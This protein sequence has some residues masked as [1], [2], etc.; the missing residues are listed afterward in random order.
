[1]MHFDKKSYLYRIIKVS[2]IVVT[3][4]LSVALIYAAYSDIAPSKEGERKIVLATPIAETS[5]TIEGVRI[6][7]ED[8]RRADKPAV[9]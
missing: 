9:R 8:C 5:L 2:A 3:A 1:M 6:V 4:L 7:V